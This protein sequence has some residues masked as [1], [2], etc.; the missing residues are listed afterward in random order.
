M[1]LLPKV[2][3]FLENIKFKGGFDPQA[4]SYVCPW[5][6]PVIQP[7]LKCSV[8]VFLCH[9]C[10]NHICADHIVAVTIY[11]LVE[12]EF[13]SISCSNVRVHVTITQKVIF[14]YHLGNS[15]LQRG[16]DLLPDAVIYV[17]DM[18]VWL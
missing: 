11:I 12:Y 8:D 16:L 10:A 14:F 15:Y 3:K 9:I 5:R 4:P 7:F 17:D 18:V 13:K 1:N 6:L 2:T